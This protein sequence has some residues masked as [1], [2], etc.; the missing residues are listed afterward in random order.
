MPLS[1]PV[2]LAD[3][4]DLGSFNCSEPSLN[5]WLQKRARSNAASGASNVFVCCDGNKVVGYY[6]TSASSVLH[7]DVPKRL[8]RNM[9]NP[10]PV[11]LLGRLAV[12]VSQEGKGLGRSLFKD[13]AQRVN[14][15][16]D[17]IGV[18]AI[19]VHPITEQARAF[20]LKQGFVDC[21]GEHRMMVATL[22]DIRAVIDGSRRKP[23]G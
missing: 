22:K 15:A 14:Q 9:P 23:G 20:W 1:A 7:A 4:H 12:D 18:V 6:A 10:V 19:V 8:T 17:Q 13:A 5:E 21:P 11:V 2:P 16:A 3:H